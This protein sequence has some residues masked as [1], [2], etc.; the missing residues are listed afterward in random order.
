M[1]HLL[2]GLLKIPGMADLL[3]F[4]ESA[5]ETNFGKILK[6]RKETGAELFGVNFKDLAKG[7]GNLVG[8]GAPV[9]GERVAEAARKAGESGT[10]DLI[11]TTGLRDSMGRVIQSIRDAMPKPEEVKQAAKAASKTSDT[12]QTIPVPEQASRLDPIVTSLGKVGGGGYSTGTLD[13]QRENNRLT[14]ETNSLLK[15]MSG[16]LDKLGGKPQAA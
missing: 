12:G 13:A 11:D 5:V 15:G 7:A 16:K 1:A 8:A 9:L 3:G 10:A 2:K 4:D 14:G 6:D